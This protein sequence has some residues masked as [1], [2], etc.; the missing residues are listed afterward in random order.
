MTRR[1]PS[2]VAVALATAALFVGLALQEGVR[3]DIKALLLNTGSDL[4]FFSLRSGRL[5]L[6]DL[7][8][9]QALPEVTAVAG[10]GREST[11]YVQGQEYVYTWLNMTDNFPDVYRLPLSQ[12]RFFLG[13]EDS[14][15]VIGAEVADAVFGERNPIGETLEGLPIIGV[16]ARLPE[17]DAVREYLNRRVLTLH[18]PSPF[19]QRPGTKSDGGEFSA[20]L[21]RASGDISVAEQSVLTLYP[22][23]QILPIY[24]FY[25]LTT[26]GT[27]IA[28]HRV[29]ILA[30]SGLLIM[31]GVL[32][33]ALMSLSTLQ[34][35]GEI[36]IRRA[37]GASAHTVQ[38]MFLSE[39]FTL[40]FLGGIVGCAVGAV[41]LLILGEPIVTSWLHLLLVPSAVLI[42]LVAS[43]I[44]ARNASRIPPARAIARR[45]LQASGAN[46]SLVLGFATSLSI[47]LAACALVIL[48]GTTQVARLHVSHVWGR[49]DADLLLVRNPRESIIPSPNLT[50]ADAEVIEAVPGVL[51]V[52]PYISRMFDSSRTIA[53]IGSG[54]VDLALL[55][56][57]AGQMISVHDLAF[58]Q[59]V[60]MISDQMAEQMFDGVA[61]GQDFHVKGETFRILGQYVR[62]R[63]L[64]VDVIV[65][66]DFR[67]IFLP[68]DAQFLVRVASI[69]E[70]DTVAAQI[71]QAL[72]DR[73]PDRGRVI[74]SPAS[75]QQAAVS[76]FYRSASSRLALFAI[77]AGILALGEISALTRFLLKTRV[78]EIG[79]RRAIGARRVHVLTLAI[80]ASALPVLFGILL[81]AGLGAGLLPV[82]LLHVV[83]LQESAHLAV[84]I[85]PPLLIGAG[86]GIVAVIHAV[87]YATLSPTDL[88]TKGRT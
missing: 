88:L 69:D 43:W 10:Q 67:D 47:A 9:V 84:L 6:D 51:S 25:A 1:I 13:P 54:F 19:P 31:S 41:L 57:T 50:P 59:P 73:Y 23:A 60:C 44:P 15:V 4:F 61:V 39:A 36:G 72:R 5:S 86:T 40:S 30:S 37:V 21:I 12:G 27:V 11:F 81:G 17:E 26:S 87:F 46:R 64:L 58:R 55:E 34:R 82:F 28:L 35:A 45:N 56:M 80:R 16:L 33:L 42:G 75:G 18:T 62:K 76:D 52:V 65:P 7:N 79:V 22:G 32:I 20:L 78:L 71:E 63:A 68:D 83:Y 3:Q 29:L 53:L 38:K 2:I 66:L 70:I 14:G 48:A 49:I 8:S 77:V 85:I 74:A 24:Q